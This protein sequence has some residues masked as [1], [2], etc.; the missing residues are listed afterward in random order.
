MRNEIDDSAS[1]AEPQSLIPLIDFYDFDHQTSV[2][3]ASSNSNDRI[4]FNDVAGMYRGLDS[5]SKQLSRDSVQ[6]GGKR[7]PDN[8]E[9][10]GNECHALTLEDAAAQKAKIAASGRTIDIDHS[11]PLPDN[12]VCVGN[13][14]R[15]LTPDE[16]AAEKAR[17]AG[18]P[19]VK[20][21]STVQLKDKVE[22]VGDECRTLTPSEV[23]AEK[24]RIAA[25]G[26]IFEVYIPKGG[27][28]PSN[29]E[30]V[31]N[32]CRILTPEELVAEKARMGA[33]KAEEDCSNP[34]SD[35]CEPAMDC[36]EPKKENV[37]CV[38]NECIEL[39][40]EQLAA[41]KARLSELGA[42]QVDVSC[43]PTANVECV[44]GECFELTPEQAQAE[45]AR[46]EAAGA[47]PIADS[48]QAAAEK[49]KI[50]AAK[51]AKQ[52]LAWWQQMD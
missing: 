40:A 32:E 48:E 14:C 31:G 16:M 1:R 7:I 17:L 50:Q 36:C 21:G 8:V 11:K 27:S 35:C 43:H 12:V 24:A 49:A 26:H 4:Q 52:S 30:C 19:Q 13:E 37:E 15:E 38:G 39:T 18:S 23:A 3:R 9:C 41:E 28:L 6:A 29:V 20:L 2:N 51:S 44:G 42:K 47:K 45:K 33:A 34:K 25:S 46:I 22:C 10:I 5:L